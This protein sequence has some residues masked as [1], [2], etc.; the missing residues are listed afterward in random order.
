MNEHIVGTTSNVY[1][2][3]PSVTEST[4]AKNGV[5]KR[6]VCQNIEFNFQK[7]SVKF[8]A[9]PYINIKLK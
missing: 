1:R 7:K 4:H 6:N 8:K 5:M 3:E 9:S 2:K